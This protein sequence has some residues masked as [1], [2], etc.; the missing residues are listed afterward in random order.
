M[1]AARALRERGAPPPG[2][3]PTTTTVRSA[4]ALL[5]PGDNWV[6][7]TTARLVVRP[8]QTLTRI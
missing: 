8:G 3:D 1:N 4:S 6:E 7:G 2:L 5:A